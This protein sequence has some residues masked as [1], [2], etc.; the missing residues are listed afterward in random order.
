MMINRFLFVPLL[1]SGCIACTSGIASDAKPI[2]SASPRPVPAKQSATAPAKTTTIEVNGKAQTIPL[3]LVETPNFSTYLPSDRFVL[4]KNSPK[5]VVSY[6]WKREDGTKG[7]NTGI[8]V[9]FYPKEVDLANAKALVDTSALSVWGA[10]R[11]EQS[12]AID[13]AKKAYSTWLRNVTQVEIKPT[14]FPAS[15]YWASTVYHGEI[16]GQVFV[17]LSSYD[18]QD[19]DE[20]TAREAVILE[21]LKPKKRG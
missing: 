11:V 14:N 19:K 1:L 13:Y 8:G 4:D 20:F 5:D 2:A 15:R 21:N 12:P 10:R 16:N 17:V 6:S 7:E 18:L 3:S 9:I